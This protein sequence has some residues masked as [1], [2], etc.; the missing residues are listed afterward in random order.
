MSIIKDWILRDNVGDVIESIDFGD[1]APG[2]TTYQEVVAQYVGHVP[3]IISGFFLRD[4]T[5]ISP[6]SG[7]Q[8]GSVIDK[9][10]VLMWGDNL[11]SSPSDP[12]LEI[13]QTN[14]D[15]AA[16]SVDVFRSDQGSSV[17]IPLEFKGTTTKVLY[18]NNELPFSIRLTAPQSNALKGAMRMNFEIGI[19][20]SDVPD[21]L[22]VYLT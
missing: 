4:A 2:A 1:V 15:T 7:S 22:T 18:P 21:A 5:E 6:Y 20:Y 14:I 3:I 16:T 13:T 8:S 19:D 9:E 11:Y 10:E 17:G 12:G